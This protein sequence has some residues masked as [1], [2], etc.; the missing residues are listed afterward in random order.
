MHGILKLFCPKM[1]KSWWSGVS[2]PSASPML[3]EN[4]FVCIID[5]SLKRRLF[6]EIIFQKLGLAAAFTPLTTMASFISSACCA[7]C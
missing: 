3:K 2:S 4:V 6:K 5:H 1:A 7:P